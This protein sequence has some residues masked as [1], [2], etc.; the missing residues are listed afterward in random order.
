MSACPPGGRRPESSS[1][2]G[3]RPESSSPGGR[4]PESPVIDLGEEIAFV[5]P[6]QGS[7]FPGMGRELSACGA[8]AR[9]LI[10]EAESYLGVPIREWLTRADAATLADPEVAQLTIFVSSIVL[11]TELEATGFRPS[12]VAGHS[13][14]EYAALVAAGCLEWSV[15]LDLVALRARSMAAA[16]RERPGTMGAVVGLPVADLERIC[17]EHHRPDRPVVVANVNSARQ[18]VVSGDEAAVEEVLATARS[19]GALRARRLP[20]GGAYHTT[21]MEP[22]RRALEPLLVGAPLR[23]P[24]TKIVSSIDG[25]LISDPE[26]YRRL[27]IGQITAA[28][29]WHDA[30]VTLRDLGSD[31]YVEVGPGRVL[32]GLVREI[33]RSS[34]QYSA[35]AALSYAGRSAAGPGRGAA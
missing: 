20:V 3:R 34:T 16:A 35:L 10:G 7:Q 8:E 22:A 21:M 17:A 9:R 14:G 5:F 26:D 33:H 27:L 13:L 12:V 18:A 25:G 6:G 29:R 19:Q 32:S 4:R 23:P 31:A 28:V 11:L 15:A 24:S 30:V 1:P 2:G